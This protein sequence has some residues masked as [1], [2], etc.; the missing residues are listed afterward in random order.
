ME[1]DTGLKTK[2]GETVYSKI[3]NRG[4][5]VTQ[6]Y[7]TCCNTPAKKYLNKQK[8]E[9][10]LSATKNDSTLPTPA[11]GSDLGLPA[12]DVDGGSV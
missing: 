7:F 1:I 4:G 8:V 9:K 2:K 5:Q 6:T 12:S 11:S 10:L 3:I